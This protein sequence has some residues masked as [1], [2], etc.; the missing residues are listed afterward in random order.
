VGAEAARDRLAAALENDF[1]AVERQRGAWFVRI[2]AGNGGAG[3]VLG[4]AER[5]A[6]RLWQGVGAEVR[7]AVAE[8]REDA[9]ALAR[10][11][12]PGWVG[13]VPMG[14]AGAWSVRRPAAA[15]CAWGPDRAAWRGPAVPDID[16]VVELCRGL[17]APLVTDRGGV[18]SITLAGA[19]GTLRVSRS[20]P[21]GCER[22]VLYGLIDG[23]VRGPLLSAGAVTDARVELTAGPVAGAHAAAVRDGSAR[24]SAPRAERRGKAM[25]RRDAAAAADVPAG[26]VPAAETATSAQARPQIAERPASRQLTLL[27][28]G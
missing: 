14:A 9:A 24:V 20:V 16:G 5:L 6:V 23:A 21:A 8:R 26:D 7:I 17:A 3:T 10:I 12:D 25:V 2:S 13:C 4:A 27:A 22:A 19:R 28:M 11:L 15:R 18:L 1:G